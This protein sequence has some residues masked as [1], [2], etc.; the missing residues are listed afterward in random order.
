MKRVFYILLAYGLFACTAQVQPQK[1]ASA[2]TDTLSNSIDTVLQARDTLNFTVNQIDR[3]NYDQRK[4]GAERL[5]K[6]LKAAYESG[7][8]GLDSVG[9]A[10]EDYMLN[11]IIPHWYGTPWDFEGHTNVPNEGEVACGYLV[12]TTLR[13]M[14]IQINR[15]HLAQQAAS[16]EAKTLAIDFD[17]I[18]TYSQIED[19][20]NELND[21]LYMVGLS[22]HVGYLLIKEGKLYFIHSNYIGAEGVTI[23]HAENSDALH[24]SEIYVLIRIGNP[25]LMK[26][27]LM[28]SPVKVYRQ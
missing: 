17:Q 26:Q 15:Y 10:F 5:R 9:Q 4:A 3:V 11:K 23:E 24:S 7:E 18:K 6:E 20:K 12:S 28:G 2:V 13:H 16:N 19:F 14:N 1:S 22:Y 21:G 8:V 27:W 25:E